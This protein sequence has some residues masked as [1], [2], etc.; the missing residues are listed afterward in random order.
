MAEINDK[1]GAGEQGDNSSVPNESAVDL[2]V[3]GE[4]SRI[5]IGG[6][7]SPQVRN[8]TSNV[9]SVDG[10]SRKN[11]ITAD[12]GPSVD[13]QSRMRPP[14][15]DASPD[16]KR[17]PADSTAQS[18][19]PQSLEGTA[20]KVVPEVT[21]GNPLTVSAPNR[22]APEARPLKSG[23][24][25]SDQTPQSLSPVAGRP[26]RSVIPTANK[27]VNSAKNETVLGS[28]GLPRGNDVSLTGTGD[29]S[30]S[31]TPPQ[32][33]IVPGSPTAESMQRGQLEQL[34]SSKI[35]LQSSLDGTPLSTG[36]Q[37]MQPVPSDSQR[38]GDVHSPSGVAGSATGSS[39]S[40]SL[41]SGNLF[42]RIGES[43]NRTAGERNSLAAGSES[44]DTKS[45][46]LRAEGQGHTAS[47]NSVDARAGA[48][49]K[50]GD[51]TGRAI[52]G[53]HG[54]IRSGSSE[55][56][57][58]DGKIADSSGSGRQP[59]LTG[60]IAEPGSGK[61][62]ADGTDRT[63]RSDRSHSDDK[64]GSGADIPAVFMQ[65][66]DTRIGGRGAS[67]FVGSR[68]FEWPFG[69]KAK[70]DPKGKQDQREPRGQKDQIDHKD[71]RDQKDQA[72]QKGPKDSREAKDQKTAKDSQSQGLRHQPEIPGGRVVNPTDDR[73]PSRAGVNAGAD[74]GGGAALVGAGA[75]IV[76]EFVAV[77][78]G[79]IPA[80]PAVRTVRDVPIKTKAED[81]TKTVVSPRTKPSLNLPADDI[82]TTRPV[83]PILKGPARPFVRLHNP[84]GTYGGALPGGKS[85]IQRTLGDTIKNP[86]IAHTQG[87]AE[88]PAPGGRQQE[89][90]RIAVPLRSDEQSKTLESIPIFDP[91][92]LAKAEKT[93]TPWLHDPSAESASEAERR[94][95]LMLEQ[96]DTLSSD[97][98]D[99]AVSSPARRLTAKSDALVHKPKLPEKN[100][101]PAKDDG[102]SA[103][104]F[105]RVRYVNKEI[106]ELE[107]TWPLADEEQRSPQSNFLASNSLFYVVKPGDTIESLALKLLGDPS[108]AALL[109][110]KNKEYVL[111][112][113]RYGVHDLMP[114]ATIELPSPAE[115]ARFRMA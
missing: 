11:Q 82:E 44:F 53:E 36:S 48:D 52:S 8:S 20:P 16:T 59:E 63:S 34:D 89:A 42:G 7:K 43:R 99:D 17:S 71:R 3:Y 74:T 80:Q 103:S 27:D 93:P 40:L 113:Q 97:E 23:Y 41:H 18:A 115:I 94:R 70:D 39:D 98:I 104:D 68:N 30:Q 112:E 102:L 32:R 66:L 51:A 75:R 4:S 90:S 86:T 22:V 56:K 31:A 1:L 101:V 61:F 28:P 58:A 107:Q 84:D 50:E 55:I 72:S 26:D 25:P 77:L 2:D 69:G 100:E 64:G 12:Q 14:A 85:P 47:V 65:F 87:A 88:Q 49:N 6:K 46:G 9:S 35:G 73:R 37:R 67:S 62:G 33:A 29:I 106:D 60:H 54:E 96:D 24:E 92:L 108:L 109:F 114:G 95:R 57:L 10:T 38:T 83:K 45:S 81:S 79:F 105:R 91:S 13:S 78:K 76:E 111:A 110:E 19:K 15:S 5:N 21:V